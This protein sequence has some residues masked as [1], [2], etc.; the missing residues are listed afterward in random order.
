M[1]SI[2]IIGHGFVGRAIALGLSY[3]YSVKIYDI[4]PARRVNSFEDT[5]NSDFVFLC[6]P[7]PMMYQDGGEADLS[8]LYDTLQKIKSQNLL[9]P[10]YIIKSTVPIGTTDEIIKKYN[11]KIIH[12]P[13][14]LTA[15]KANIDFVTPSRII[16]GGYSKWTQQ[17]ANFYKERFPGSNI[18][19]MSAR[20]SEAV[21]Y[22]NN[23]FFA[24]KVMFF[25]EMRLGLEKHYGLDWDRVIEGVMTDGRIAY[26]HYNV[27]G[28]DGKPGFGGS[29]VLPDAKIKTL[30]NNEVSVE[31]ISQLYK[32]KKFPILVESTDSK[33]EKINWK[34]VKTITE[35]EIDE[36]IYCFRTNN[37]EFICTS[38][39]Y[40][41]VVRNNEKIIIQAQEIK[42][43]DLLFLK[44]F[45]NFKTVK[46]DNITKKKYKGNVYNLELESKSD[47]EDDLFWIEQNTGIVTH[48]C[49]PKDIASLIE[50]INK[51]GFDPLMLKA[52]WE[53]N[54]HIRPEMDW[55]DIPSAVRSE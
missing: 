1:T 30:V 55:K 14:F 2:G 52:C 11:L 24:T 7:T 21:K 20:E 26:S 39:H 49:F 40:M 36:E 17:V 47:S 42:E 13:E 41:P 6:L 18:L 5:C 46:I 23:C 51:T 44:I 48:N 34:T 4:D 8:I 32:N 50:Q 38:D 45:M 28:H 54:K 15:L 27:P 9:N 33:I 53:Q 10:I 3:Y 29:C 37:K 35:R 31:W 25:N 43:S 19:T 22:I 12:N 16:V